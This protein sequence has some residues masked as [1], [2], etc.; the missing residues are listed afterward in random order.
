[1][2]FLFKLLLWLT[3][4]GLLLAMAGT[5]WVIIYVVPTLPPT[6]LLRD[7]RMQVPMRVYSADGK[8][9]AE[10]GE[11]R[12]EP[13]A[14]SAIPKQLIQAFLAA[15]DDRFFEHPGVDYQGLARA[16]VQLVLTGRRAQGGSTIT[17]QLVKNVLLSPEKTYSRKLKEV[18]L[19]LRI[20]REL[21]K[22][23]ILELYLNKIFLGHRAYGVA[24]AAQVYYGKPVTELNLAEMATIAGLPKAPS[25]FNPIVNPERS[26]QRRSYV[27]RRMRDLGWIDEQAFTSAMATPETASLHGVAI[28]LDAPY[29]AEM[30]RAE[31]FERFGQDAYEKGL[32]LTTTL[33]S[34]L[35]QTAEQVVRTH[36][37]AYEERH[38][39][40][41]PEQRLGRPGA[42]KAQYDQVLAT[43]P[44]VADL[45]PALVLAVETK[46]ALIYI[47]DHGQAILEWPEMS[48]ARPYVN[49]SQRGPTPK[50]A[51]DILSPGDL[52]RVRQRPPAVSGQ[53]KASPEPSPAPP[54]EPKWRLSQIPSVE[55]S[56]VAIDPKDGAIKALVGG[57]DFNRSK[58][59]LVSQAKRQAGSGFKVVIY[60][61]ALDNGYSPASLV[62]DA[63]V[64]FEAG[65]GQLSDWRPENYGG[66]FSGPTRL[67]VALA[68][69]LNMVSIR[70]LQDVG[71]KKT[72]EQAARFGFDPQSVPHNFTLALGT[73]ET[74]PLEMA[75][76]Y[77]V[78]ANGGFLIQPYV[79]N[80]I[81]D[82]TKDALYKADPEIACPACETDPDLV[83][84]KGRKATRSLSPQN[85]FLMSS[86]L[87]EV[88]RA[89]TATDAKRLGRSDLA[90][91]TGTTNQQKDAWFYGFH[92]DLVAVTWLGFND[93]RPL[94]K[95]ETGGK[96]ALPIWID[97]MAEALKTLPK[98][99]LIP[100]EGIERQR[101][102]P[103]TGRPA[104]KGQKKALE[105]FVW[106][107][108]PGN[109]S[110]GT[111]VTQTSEPGQVGSMEANGQP[112]TPF[113]PD[114]SVE[115][116]AAP[117]LDESGPSS[118]SEDLF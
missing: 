55:G 116:A 102:D 97:F 111:S 110:D 62:N 93:S 91:K 109:A 12:R 43:I 41:G 76:A 14:Y 100:P 86:M 38:G 85:A 57:Y 88:I 4:A 49:E 45:K 69:S 80:S 28:E 54:P 50:S 67:R 58:F 98:R 61:A 53:A 104:A 31:A 32:N 8:L 71:L 11:K 105:E 74:S 29:V 108:A 17:M 46:T 99:E 26:L 21:P 19:A 56:L 94:G 65:Q 81:T 34:S 115:G 79:L 18:L 66:K 82:D 10:Y 63:P 92:P 15:E 5:A 36:A 48:W 22:E 30:A 77:S 42:N 78:L 35:Q 73:A 75:R 24:A 13:L 112:E 83:L 3:S 20:D 114:A 7:V 23:Q 39:Y 2:R 52:I 113:Q 33:D 1:M 40:R 101:I 68:K 96:A 25:R 90:G 60:S 107:N 64:M 117:T 95:D 70:L 106:V 51:K 118:H 37:Q 9:M 103:A 16:V 44:L 87:Q 27:L 72:L 59:N 6:D 84:T 47:K 89:G